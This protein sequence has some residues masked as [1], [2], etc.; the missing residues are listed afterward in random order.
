MKQTLVLLIIVFSYFSSSAQ[1]W[2]SVLDTIKPSLAPFGMES[3]MGWIY[4][5]DT[6]QIIY[7]ELH[8]KCGWSDDD[9]H[10]GYKRVYVYKGMYIDDTTTMNQIWDRTWR[11]VKFVYE[12]AFN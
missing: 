11:P 9:I 4:H 2:H 6:V 10:F 3:S 8:P 5:Y 7:K 12:Y 1:H